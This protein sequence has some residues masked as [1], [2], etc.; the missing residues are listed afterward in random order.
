[1]DGSEKLQLV[2]IGKSVKPQSFKNARQIPV[3]YF[4]NDAAWM[5]ASIFKEFLTKLNNRLEREDRSIILFIDNCA[6]HPKLQ[7]SQI[8]LVFFPPNTTSRLQPMDAGIIKCLKGYYRNKVIRKLIAAIDVYQ[9]KEVNGTNFISFLDAIL[10]LKSAWGE[11]TSATISNCFSKCGFF[12]NIEV[13]EDN[14]IF[15][16][17]LIN[18]NYLPVEDFERFV[19][20][21]DNIC[22]YDELHDEEMCT[23]QAIASETAESEDDLE[24]HQEVQQEQQEPIKF[25]E[26]INC[27]EMIKRF[28]SQ[29]D[30][31]Y[32]SG[33]IL[34]KLD[35]LEN[36]VSK[37]TKFI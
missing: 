6:A 9:H 17:C 22:A 4:S 18:Q 31:G 1:M 8:K 14:L 12:K 11:V 27:I 19:C 33:L 15:E 13:V 23:V 26:V 34:D 10:M 35:D 5:N 36:L 32:T 25:G 28:A 20:C 3:S 16:D 21:D 24:V 37:E 29:L 7:F 2:V 30:N